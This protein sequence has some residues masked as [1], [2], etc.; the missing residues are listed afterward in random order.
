VSKV[1]SGNIRVGPAFLDKSV[2]MT[3]RANRIKT[4][5]DGIYSDVNS[6]LLE[7]E[8][9]FTIEIADSDEKIMTVIK[10][11]LEEEL[12]HDGYSARITVD[13]QD[14]SVAL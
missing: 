9:Q 6:R 14:L 3:K 7:G 4:I 2:Y 5:Y 10:T 12:N 13:K 11:I 8:R 1:K